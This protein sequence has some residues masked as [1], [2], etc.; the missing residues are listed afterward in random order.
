MSNPPDRPAHLTTD[1]PNANDP[2]LWSELLAG[3]VL[4]DLSPAEMIQVQQYLDRHPEAIAQVED[5]Q[6]T[7][8]LLPIGLP[9]VTLPDDL[10]ARVMAATAPH[11]VVPINAGRSGTRRSARSLDPS[12]ARTQGM[13]LSWPLV[14]TLA[15]AAIGAFGLQSYLLHQEMAATRQ[16]IAQLRTALGQAQEASIGDANRQQKALSV[17]AQ[18]PGR[19][20]HLAGSGPAASATGTVVI[21][22]SQKRAVLMLQNLPPAP[23]G[24]VYHLWAMVE[25]RK[26]AC[27]QFT[28]EAD[29]QVLMQLPAERWL[30]ATGVAITLEPEQTTEQPTGEMVM[31][32]SAL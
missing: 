6:N 12:A 10:K 30:P 14:G 7:L 26:V 28:P 11:P 9:D 16:D 31:S 22:P 24:K 13:T 4:G 32:G 21:S 20:L 19:I 3:Y 17:I 8:A 27:I 29:R 23:I 2:N 25:G 15:A 18:A 5:L 1:G